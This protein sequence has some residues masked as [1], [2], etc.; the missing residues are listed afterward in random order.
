MVLGSGIRKKP[1][2]DP[3]PR[4]QKTPDPGSGSATLFRRCVSLILLDDGTGICDCDNTRLT[5][6][7]R[8]NA[9]GCYTRYVI[10]HETML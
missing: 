1:I 4:G 6:E 9:N 5:L 10:S 8:F 7:L 3:G 2:P